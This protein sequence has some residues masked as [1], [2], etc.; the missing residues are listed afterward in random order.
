MT[1]PHQGNEGRTKRAKPVRKDSTDDRMPPYAAEAEKGVLGG[2]LDGM[3]G[4]AEVMNEC[5]ERGL[6]K[7]WFYDLRHQVTW[8][9]MRM[10]HRAGKAVDVIS[11]QQVLR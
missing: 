3:G 7:E 6:V 1:T 2:V 8:D 9:G 11:L 10:L 5:E 4:S